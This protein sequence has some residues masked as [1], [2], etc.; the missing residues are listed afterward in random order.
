M[1][2][3]LRKLLITCLAFSTLMSHAHALNSNGSDG[4]F[5]VG[6]EV[7]LNVT[8]GQIL[9]FT[10]INVN[11]GGV[12]NLFATSPNASFTMLASGDIDI[13]GL[14][15]VYTNT[16]IESAGYIYVT[17]TIDLKNQ[18]SISFSSNAFINIGSILIEGQPMI[19]NTGG[20]INLPSIP[21]KI[22]LLNSPVPEPSSYALLL[23]G[24]GL[25]CLA[26]RKN[27]H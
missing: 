9:N 18:S 24:L 20:D 25:I 8:D 2:N 19:P 10:T 12:L 16:N 21:P 1:L 22:E 3:I 14:L 5:I 13:A 7:T 6:G 27:Q 15:N 23:S 26:R 11:S 17:G 4:A